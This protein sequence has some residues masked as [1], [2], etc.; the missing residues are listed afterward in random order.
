MGYDRRYFLKKAYAL[1]PG[2]IAPVSAPVL[3]EHYRRRRADRGAARA[4]LDAAVGAAFLAWVPWRAR[5]V[6]RRFGLDS[7]WRARAVA[8]ARARFADPNDLALF[9]IAE[10]GALDH[11][12][13][14]FEDAAFNKRINPAGWGGAC[15]LAD[16]A[17]F[18]ARCAAL[19]LPHA[20]TLA[21]VERGR[22]TAVGPLDGVPLVVK[23]VDGEGGAGVR[24]LDGPFDATALPR[25]GRH[26]VQRR[27][28]AHPA[29]AGLSDHALPTVRIVTILDEQRRPEVV[30]ATFRCAAVAGA[31]VDNMKAGG[32]IAAVD[33]ATGTL[34]RA[35]KGYGGGDYD[36]HPLTG[37]AI[38]GRVLPDWDAAAALARR[39]HAEGFA[40]YALI[41]WDLAL[42]PAGP[43]LVE[44]NAK[45]GVLMPQRAAGRG[46][47]EGRYG[48]LLAHHL[49]LAEA[50]TVRQA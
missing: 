42:A 5:G 6:A 30:S 21:L 11:Y 44:G 27:I 34:G 16:K 18:A 9:G 26:V 8:I 29:L 17:R 36:T 32:L 40:G 41:G 7:A 50:R 19:G 14:R 3:A 49:A 22:I 46:L 23:P 10:A 37:A 25:T 31:G 24:H 35:R 15:V 12:I 39:A 48:A 4:L 13:R 28:G 2:V 1:Y 47:G 43:M 20:E 33:L 45:P 38:A